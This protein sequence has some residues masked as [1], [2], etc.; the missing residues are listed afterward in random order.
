MVFGNCGVLHCPSLQGKGYVEMTSIDPDTS[1]DTNDAI[2][3]KGGRYLEA[4]VSHTLPF[5]FKNIFI[6]VFTAGKRIGPPPLREHR[7]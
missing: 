3:E 2:C 5:K 6:Y 4:Q 7:V 1:K